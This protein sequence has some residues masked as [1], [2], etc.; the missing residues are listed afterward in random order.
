MEQPMQ[1]LNH[2]SQTQFCER[3]PGLTG[4]LF[5]RVEDGFPGSGKLGKHAD[6]DSFDVLEI[7]DLIDY[8]GDGPENIRALPDV[9][10]I[11]G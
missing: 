8:G 6:E 2:A 3:S 5:K 9:A 11:N 1:V 7:L 10:G 4:K